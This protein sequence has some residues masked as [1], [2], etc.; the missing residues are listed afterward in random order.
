M[1]SLPVTGSELLKARIETRTARI[2][3]TGLGY[4][5]LP[6]APLLGESRLVIDTRNAT[7]GLKAENIV[8][9]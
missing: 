3:V 5:G 2:G 7:R 8:R 9:R 4:V 1:P 6:P